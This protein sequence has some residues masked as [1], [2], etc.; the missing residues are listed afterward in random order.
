VVLVSGTNG[1]TST[2]HFTARILESAGKTTIVNRSGANL[3][4]AITSTLVSAAGARGRLHRPGSIA[5]LEVD[6]A[7]LPAAVR[8]LPVRV[9]VLTNLFRDQLDRFG[10]TDHLVRLWSGMLGG[11]AEST[12]VVWCADDP[13]LTALVG[14]RAGAVGYGLRRP[15]RAGSTAQVTSDVSA[16]P[17]CGVPLAYDW[18]AVGHLGAYACPSCGFVRPDPWLSVTAT[19]R[20]FEGQTLDLSWRG[21]LAD[22]AGADPGA[23]ERGSL[24]VDVHVPTLGN[25]YNAAAAVTAAA[26]LGV[27]PPAAAPALAAASVPFA[28]FETL[29]VDGRRVVLSLV[30]NPASLGELTRTIADSPASAVASV[31]FV[32][33][34]NFQDGRDV[35]WYWDVDPA[36]MVRDRPFVIAG[37]R[38]PDFAL[39]LKYEL[40]DRPGDPIPGFLGLAATPAD[41]LARALAAI[42][43]GATC[44]VVS[45]Y[46]ALLALR[47][48]L[49]DR[50]LATAMPR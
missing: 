40:V 20:G 43:P 4:Q 35:S 6:E 15:E 29:M 36:P 41:G 45:T 47:A 14:D 24:R 19:E 17:V 5:V 8:I 44:V 7:V 34:D 26:V 32:F 22:R 42:P 9:L 28:R 48:T 49:V 12:T 46:T 16:C 21:S 2:T 50:G 27:E 18:T 38:A 39:R 37:R 10:E 31:L 25:A 23:E 11:L 13:R 1:K 33:S 3:E 30:K